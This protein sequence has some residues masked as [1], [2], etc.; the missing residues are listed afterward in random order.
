[1]DGSRRNQ[2]AATKSKTKYANPGELFNHELTSG[3]IAAPP[4]T[5]HDPNY[6]NSNVTKDAV[7]YANRPIQLEQTVQA[8]GKIQYANMSTVQQ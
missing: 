1:M 5:T 7:I 3:A 2:T 4:S 8:N 6:L